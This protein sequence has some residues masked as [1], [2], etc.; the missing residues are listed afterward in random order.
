MAAEEAADHRRIKMP[1]C[2][3][4][5][6]NVRKGTGKLYVYTSGKIANFCSHKCEKNLLKLKRKPLQ[7]RWTQEWIKENKK[8]ST[9]KKEKVE[10]AP[11]EEPAKEK[12]A[13]EPIVETPKEEPK[14][15]EK[16][17]VEEKTEETVESAKEETILPEQTEGEK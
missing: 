10:E 9:E 16:L 13:E 6:N 11:K 7:T 8:D 2:T 4:C 1:K 3:F 12:V 15:E 17:P 5:G 14:T